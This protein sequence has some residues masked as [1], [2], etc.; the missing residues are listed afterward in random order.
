MVGP[1]WSNLNVEAMQVNVVQWQ[2][3]NL[4]KCNQLIDFIAQC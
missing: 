2:K 1:E 3:K 4:N